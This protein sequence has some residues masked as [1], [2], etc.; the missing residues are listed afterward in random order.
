MHFLSLTY[1]NRVYC[2]LIKL[3]VTFCDWKWYKAIS[4]GDIECVKDTESL[5]HQASERLSDL[6]NA[7][8]YF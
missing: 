5:E 8:M 6:T 2:N 1:Y 7:L 4:V 3:V